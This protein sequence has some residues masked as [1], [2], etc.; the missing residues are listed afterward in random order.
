MAIILVTYALDLNTPLGVPVCLLYFVL[1]ILVFWYKA[2]Y[3]VPTVCAVTLL[4]LASGVVFSPPGI[5]ISAALFMRIV[6][7]VV[8]IGTSIALWMVL[9]R[10]GN[11][12]ASYY[13]QGEVSSVSVAT[14]SPL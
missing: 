4:V 9:R 7:S 2:P 12:A 6:F 1:L 3:A 10:Q 8:F 14:A 5:Q 13:L 11:R